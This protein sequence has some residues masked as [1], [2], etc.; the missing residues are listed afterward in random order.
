MLKLLSPAGSAEAV[1]A[2]VQSG[3]DIVHIGFGASEAEREGGFTSGELARCLRYC[4]V[5]GCRAVVAVGELCSDE[6]LPRAV[7]RAVYAARAGA[8]ALLLQDLG[9]AA[10]LRT[11]LPGTP[12]W[13]GVRLGLRTLP[14]V[15]AA[16]ALGF[17]RVMLSPGL[18]LE[19]IARIAQNAGVPVGV[20]VHGPMCFARMGR[21][22]MS[23]LLDSGK[24]DSA[25]RCS[26]PCRGRFSLGGRMDDCP[27][28][29]PDLCLIEQIGRAHV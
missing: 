4:R 18:T 24:S 19:Q 9:L 13:A 28:S 3:A 11:A 29:T 27:L 15:L 10:A 20:C 17:S 5:R 2:A 14:E 23:A 1:I 26:E 6:T 25:L 16:K 22:H 21:C 8:D 7:D 12:L